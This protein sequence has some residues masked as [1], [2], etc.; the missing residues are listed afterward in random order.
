MGSLTQFTRGMIIPL[1]GGSGPIIFQWNP[2]ELHINKDIK[3]K[4]LHVA[5]AEA[6]YL[7][8]GC[9]EPRHI[10]I[11]IEVSQDN[12]S[13]FFV[14]GQLDALL[15]LSKCTVKGQGVD[16]PPRLL[17]QLGAS[18]SVTCIVDDIRVR[19][20]SHVGQRHHFTYLAH[21][22]TLLP[23]EGNVVA[24]FLEDIHFGQ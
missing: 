6:A 11:G 18:L 21:P 1:E 16:R 15:D 22:D 7:E 14:K 12:N 5:G 19:Y 3:W 8:Y 17:L 23:R 20:G 10:S 13:D 2:Y 4:P 9:G 24:R